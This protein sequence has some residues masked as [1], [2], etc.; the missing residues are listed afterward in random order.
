MLWYLLILTILFR[1]DGFLPPK[2]FS[3]YFTLQSCNYQL[4]DGNYS[5]N[6][7]WTL[8]SIF[9]FIL[10]SNGS[11]VSSK[12]IKIFSKLLK[13][14]QIKNSTY[15]KKI[16]A[17]KPTYPSPWW[18]GGNRLNVGLTE[19]G[20]SYELTSSTVLWITWESERLR[21]TTLAA[22]QEEYQIQQ[23]VG[24]ANG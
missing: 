2:D 19:E 3:D 9:M 21:E 15:L 11:V 7:F 4:T 1:S 18:A 6:V 17:Q 23:C 12:N 8:N 5:R 22:T 10:F 16:I 14:D 24:V 20:P 13:Y